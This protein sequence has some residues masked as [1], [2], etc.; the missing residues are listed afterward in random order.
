MMNRRGRWQRRSG[1]SGA[2]DHDQPYTFGAL[3]TAERP[4]P[5]R[6]FQYARLL[7]LR[8]ELREGAYRDDREA[9]YYFTQHDGTVW[10]EREGSTLFRRPTEA[11]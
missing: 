9:R 2:G 3:P 10:V 7:M 11:S 5:F 8:G 6:L 1:R 4:F